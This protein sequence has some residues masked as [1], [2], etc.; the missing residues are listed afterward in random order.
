MKSALV[1]ALLV[2]FKAKFVAFGL[3][4]FTLAAAFL[5]H[6]NFANQIQMIMFLKNVTIISG[7]LLVVA[8]GAGGFSIDNCK[9]KLIF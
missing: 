4:M 5:Y 6:N 2:G 9:N 8:H 3:A 7:L 1:F